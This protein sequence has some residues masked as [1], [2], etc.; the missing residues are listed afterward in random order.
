MV[1]SDLRNLSDIVVLEL[2]DVPNDLALV[3]ANG[4]EHEQVLEVLVVAERRRLNDN[5]LEDL[6]ELDRKVSCDESLDG[7]RDIIRV[8]ALGKGS[9]DDLVNKLTAMDVV[10][11]EN[12]GPKLKLTAFD[13]VASLL[14]EHGIV[15]RDSDELFVAETFGV[16]DIREVRIAL[17]A[18]LSDNKRLIQL[19]NVL[20]HVVVRDVTR[21]TLFSLR[22]ASGLLLLSM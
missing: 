21:L 19:Y 6:N 16:C 15:V 13:K 9:R 10:R 7:H 5:L 20:A 2:V 3:S 12:H 11:N 14:L 22:D 8:G 18:V 17:L 4:S 1:N